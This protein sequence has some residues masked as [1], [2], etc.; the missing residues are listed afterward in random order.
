MKVRHT[1]RYLKGDAGCRDW[2]GLPWC[3]LHFAPFSKVTDDV[4]Q[5]LELSWVITQKTEVVTEGC[6]CNGLTV[7]M[8]ETEARPIELAK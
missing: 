8:S 1:P 6:D 3:D 5:A 7:G 2:N 4:E